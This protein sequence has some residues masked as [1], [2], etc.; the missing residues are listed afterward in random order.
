MWQD[1]KKLF[2]LFLMDMLK[3]SWYSVPEHQPAW[4]YP[5]FSFL[6]KA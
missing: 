6:H 1:F 5:S 3:L 2:I 4:V